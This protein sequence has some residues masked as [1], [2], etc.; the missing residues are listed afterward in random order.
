[1]T[2]RTTLYAEDGMIW[3]DGIHFGSIIHLAVGADASLYRKITVKEY[4]EILAQSLPS[5][6]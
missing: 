6:S 1:M 5:E 3:T 4:E 2:T